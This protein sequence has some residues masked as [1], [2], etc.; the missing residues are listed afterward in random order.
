MSGK[1][2]FPEKVSFKLDPEPQS[3]SRRELGVGV[4]GVVSR[5]FQAEDAERVPCAGRC[6]LGQEQ[7]LQGRVS[8]AVRGLGT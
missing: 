5:I 3:V 7:Q 1:G 2:H 4:G 6:R 8:V